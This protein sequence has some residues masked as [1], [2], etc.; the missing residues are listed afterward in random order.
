MGNGQGYIYLMSNLFRPHQKVI[1]GI[2]TIVLTK[3]SA[4]PLVYMVL[5]TIS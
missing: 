4:K 5:V 3:K 2:H 1:S